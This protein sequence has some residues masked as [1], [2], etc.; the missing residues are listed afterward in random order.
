MVPDRE[1]AAQAENGRRPAVARTAADGPRED[2][3]SPGGVL[4]AD[5]AWLLVTGVLLVTM[6]ALTLA[7]AYAVLTA[8]R[9]A[10]LDGLTP[11]EIVELYVV[12]LGAFALF[13]Y[14]LY[15]VA[16]YGARREERG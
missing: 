5:R 1:Q 4:T 16:S 2:A 15:R 10:V 14:L 8:T 11:V 13:A 7:V 6:P 9:S 3:A 12:E